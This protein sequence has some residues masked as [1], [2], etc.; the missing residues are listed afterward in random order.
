VFIPYTYKKAEVALI[1]EYAGRDASWSNP[2]I[3]PATFRM[4]LLLLYATGATQAELLSL[5]R[6][7]VQLITK[8]ITLHNSRYKTTRRIPISGELRDSI[9]EYLSGRCARRSD[10]VFVDAR[11]AQLTPSDLLRRFRILCRETGVVRTD[12]HAFRP[13]LL[14]LRNTF[15]VHRIAGWIEK[16]HNLTALLP[17]LAA[18]MG[19][20]SLL[21]GEHYLRLTPERFHKH[22]NAL[23]PLQSKTPWRND[24]ELMGIVERAQR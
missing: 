14:D 15:A 7:D 16:G 17:A 18:Y 8:V 10:S 22:L 3:E 6:Q 20:A 23:C 4:I 1:L 2:K 11:G 13:R 21:S 19:S 24:S 12:G 5:R 9:G